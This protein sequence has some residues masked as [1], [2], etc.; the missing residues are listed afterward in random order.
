MAKILREFQGAVV[1]ESYKGTV[2][3]GMNQA[4][5]TAQVGYCTVKGDRTTNVGE[6]NRTLRRRQR[7]YMFK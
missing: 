1:H 7:P 6:A 2:L 5:G 3:Y 4:N